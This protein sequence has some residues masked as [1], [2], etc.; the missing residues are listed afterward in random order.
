MCA[1][2]QSRHRACLFTLS[3]S[4]LPWILVGFVQF[5]KGFNCCRWRIGFFQTRT[6]TTCTAHIYFSTLA[7]CSRVS[8]RFRLPLEL[9]SNQIKKSPGNFFFQVP[10]KRKL[11]KKQKTSKTMFQ[12]KNAASL[13]TTSPLNVPAGDSGGGSSF[14][15]P[16]GGNRGPD[17]SGKAIKMDAPVVKAWKQASSFTKYSY[18]ILGFFILLIFVGY[19]YLRYWNG[20][21]YRI[22]ICILMYIYIYI[23][24][25]M[26]ITTKEGKWRRQT[27][28]QKSSFIHSLMVSV[29]YLY[30]VF[31][32]PSFPLFSPLPSF[33]I[34]N[35]KPLFGWLAIN[36]SVRWN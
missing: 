27:K 23:S 11:T 9:F 36:K 28:P 2:L 17:G 14:G 1:P 33:L 32:A 34:F 26:L 16:M 10:N 7:Y 29:M 22:Y 18:Y 13:P 4:P 6:T 35:R 12:R 20:K 30:Y 25:A 31:C 21:C 8:K 19:R 5:N 15:I 3:L 24:D